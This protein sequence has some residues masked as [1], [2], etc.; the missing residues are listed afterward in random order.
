MVFDLRRFHSDPH[1]GNLFALE[2]DVIGFVDFGRVST[3]SERALD[4]TADCLFALAHDDASGVTDIVLQVTHADPEVDSDKLRADIEEMMDRYARAEI[5]DTMGQSV[6]S[7][8]LDIV[9]SHDLHLPSEYAM[10]FQTFGILQG[11][12]AK[13]DPET[14]LL[15]IAEPYIERVALRR[16]P[17]RASREL[18][19]QL[20]QY[21]RLMARLPHALDSAVQQLERGE[22]GVRFKVDSVDEILA[23]TESMFDRLSLTILLS[24]MAIALALAAGQP[25]LLP[26][27]RYV[28]Q[29][30]LFLVT[31]AAAWLFWSVASSEHRRRRPK[32]G[33]G[34]R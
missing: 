8:M 5:A 30:L 32:R 21:G 1:P 14:K 19:D 24:A 27:V 23:R 4:R 11:V 25:A 31:V 20:R 9:R 13:L 33:A 7:E 10:L 6:L 28:A 29:G 18:L 12:V 34:G 26:W 2:G 3:L 17:E 16:L 15:D 22:L